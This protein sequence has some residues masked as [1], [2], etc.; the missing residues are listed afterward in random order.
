M[1]QLQ[2]VCPLVGRIS[3]NADCLKDTLSLRRELAQIAISSRTARLFGT[4]C[5]GSRDM[6]PVRVGMSRM[7]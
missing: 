4:N 6:H 3:T 2:G 7:R 1:E 5:C